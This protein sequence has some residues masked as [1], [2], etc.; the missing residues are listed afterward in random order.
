VTVAVG[1]TLLA[2]VEEH[3]PSSTSEVHVCIRAED[4]TLAKGSDR[5]SSARN[6]LPAVVQ[7]LTREGPLMRVELNC[8]F[9]LTALLTKQACEE[10]LLKSGD[11]VVALVKAPHV[12]LIP[13]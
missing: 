5:P 3:L 2:A 10:M 7:S 8:G 4:V 12:H 9:N 6:H 11:Q 13:R 1:P